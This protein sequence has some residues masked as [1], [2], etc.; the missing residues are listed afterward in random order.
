MTE[1][2]V[3]SDTLNNFSSGQ[4]YV[5]HALVADCYT[6]SIQIGFSLLDLIPIVVLHHGPLHPVHDGDGV[7]GD[8]LL[9]GL[10]S[11]SRVTSLYHHCSQTPMYSALIPLLTL[12]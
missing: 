3:A 7:L 2:I 10:L 1:I 6:W 11:L 12:R 9:V 5:G 4:L 8:T